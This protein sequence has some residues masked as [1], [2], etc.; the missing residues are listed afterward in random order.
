MTL[1]RT[2]IRKAAG[3]FSECFI[4]FGHE[5]WDRPVE[6]IIGFKTLMHLHLD[7]ACSVTL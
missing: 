1:T 6:A 4:A 7:A 3:F 2:R 5:E